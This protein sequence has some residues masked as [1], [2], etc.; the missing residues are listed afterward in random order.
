MR[1]LLQISFKHILINLT[2]SIGTPNSMRIA[3]SVYRLRYGLDDLGSIPGRGSDG[4][5][6]FATASRPALGPT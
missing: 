5:F 6:F 3:Q 2:S 1:S 4:I